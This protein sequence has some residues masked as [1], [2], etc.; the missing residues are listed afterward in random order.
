ML[1]KELI[2][3][4]KNNGNGDLG[5]LVEK[6]H[7]SGSISFILENLGFLPKNFNGSFL[8]DLLKHEHH[9]VRLLAVKNIGKIGNESYLD[10]LS[11][12]LD[13]EVNTSV[14]REV[15]SS[16]GRMRNSKNKKVLYKILQDEDPKIV[17]QA[18]RALLVFDK[19][20]EVK[21][22][23]KLLVNHPNE[24]VRT[25]IY[26]EFFADQESKTQ[27]SLP[28]AETH[29]FLKN[30]VVNGDVLEVL[31]YVPNESVHLT[32]TSPPYYNARDY[33]IYPSYQAYLEFLETVFKETHRITKEGRFLIIN[34]SP[35]IIPRVSRS[36][37]SKRYPIPFDLHQK[38]KKNGWEFIDD[39]VWQKPDYSVKNRIGGF[40][41]HRKPLMYKPNAVTEYLM[42][43]R[44]ETTKLI[45]WNIRSYDKET[46][47]QSKVADGYETT[48]VWKIVPCFDKV[49]SAVFP[50]E[51]CKRVIQY[52]SFKGDLVFDPFG[53]S[54]TVGKTAKALGRRFFL[55]E[56]EPTY[57]EYMKSKAKP[58]LL[59][60]DRSKF[61]TLQD[62]KQE[63][64][65][66]NFNTMTDLVQ[67]E[68]KIFNYETENDIFEVILTPCNESQP[69][70]Y[71]ESFKGTIKDTL[72][73]SLNMI[74]GLKQLF[75][76]GNFSVKIEDTKYEQIRFVNFGFVLDDNG[77]IMGSINDYL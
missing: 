71:Y 16:I 35:I 60:E 53:G 7:D 6:Q 46:T 55:T 70:T 18:I 27:S 32:F 64:L 12:M 50:V 47:E 34:T 66:Q 25:V 67:V 29:D 23:L 56:Q 49:H 61:L 54:G 51:L 52:Y 10:S 22:Q 75:P 33:S 5:Y 4:F 68:T 24:M 42:V 14:K 62:F 20:N 30:T 72:A 74:K 17:C 3:E 37:S 41:Q 77:K 58:N 9:Q 57:F 39:I 69:M 8:I 21:E 36:H 73:R 31:K 15:V 19:D 28:H 59:D 45:D 48:N 44:K 2:T 65:S 26:K 11:Q 76:K 43:Y 63:Y 13:N 1:T 40:M 38:K